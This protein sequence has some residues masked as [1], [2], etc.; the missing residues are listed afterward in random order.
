M[1]TAPISTISSSPLSSSSRIIVI[2]SLPYPGNVSI[3][4]VESI[5][6][7]SSANFKSNSPSSSNKKIKFPIQYYVSPPSNNLLNRNKKVSI[8]FYNKSNNNNSSVKPIL[9]CSSNSNKN[10]SLQSIKFSYY[11]FDREC[12]DMDLINPRF[13][14]KSLK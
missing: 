8:P 5:N 10:S 11:P 4:I 3:E 1:S 7:N 2:D 12:S 6:N 9:K 13:T 14:I